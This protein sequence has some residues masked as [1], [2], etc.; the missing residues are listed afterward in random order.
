MNI[1][2]PS[3]R[4]HAAARGAVV[5]CCAGLA[6]FAARASQGQPAYSLVELGP[7]I[8]NDINNLGQVVGAGG[9]GAF[10]YSGGVT[11]DLGSGLSANGINDLGQIVGDVLGGSGTQS[12]FLYSGGHLTQL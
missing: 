4:R 8:A 5:L 12:G 3:T 2:N 1:F 7:G 11:T 6:F 9:G 10:L